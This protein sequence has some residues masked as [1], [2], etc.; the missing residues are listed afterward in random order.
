MRWAEGVCADLCLQ[1]SGL[2]FT[3]NKKIKT[4]NFSWSHI[5]CDGPVWFFIPTR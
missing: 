3:K 5:Q 2:C 4:N 1:K